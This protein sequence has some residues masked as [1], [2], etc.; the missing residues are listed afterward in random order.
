MFCRTTIIAAGFLVVSCGTQK[1]LREEPHQVESY[2]EPVTKKVEKPRGNSQDSLYVDGPSVIF[3]TPENDELNNLARDNSTRQGLFQAV[4]DFAYY[5]SVVSDSLRSGQIKVLFTNKRYITFEQ[6]PEHCID[7]WQS[8]APF[9]LILYNGLDKPKILPG[10]HIHLSILAA[11]SGFFYHQEKNLLP[12]LDYFAPA[13]SRSLH[14]YSSHS[15]ILNQ[16]GNRVDPSYYPAFGAYVANRAQKFHMSVYAY[17]KFELP[18]SL[19]AIIC[20]VPSKFDESSV[21]LYIWDDQVDMVV[22]EIELA[23]NVWNEKWIMVKDS[24]ITIHPDEGNFSL[25][26]RKKEARI[27]KGK[28][29]EVDSLYQ[30]KWTRDGFESIPTHGLLISDF[31]LKDWDSYRESR[32]PTE[33]TIIDEDYAWL[34]L[35]TGDLTWKNIIMELPKPYSIDKE[36]IQNHL[37]DHQI[38]T[39]ITITRV[40]LKLK[41]YQAPDD[42]LL[43]DGVVSDRSISFKKGVKIGISKND[44]IGLFEK[45]PGYEAV[46]DL[47]KIRSKGADRVISYSFRNDTLARIEFTNFIH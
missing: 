27:E 5:A 9:G 44:F 2:A 24:W 35:E 43:I 38:D 31:P 46:P 1:D 10:M 47:I 6:D 4:G 25:V 23:E 19:Y 17:Q 16:F 11:I 15:D 21:K 12:L 45:L 8:E 36:P 41:F 26:Q 40:G 7:R 32:P 42:I 33:I 14:I 37:A 39:L 28:R 34:P 29:T 20:R 3:Y 18:D 30:W 13:G 22:D